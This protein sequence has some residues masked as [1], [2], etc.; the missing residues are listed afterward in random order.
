MERIFRPKK[1]TR[2]GAVMADDFRHFQFLGVHN[3]FTS[4]V[5]QSG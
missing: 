1:L 2:F 5:Q 3:A 4:P